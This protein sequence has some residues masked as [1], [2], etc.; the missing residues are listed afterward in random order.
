[1][2]RFSRFPELVFKMFVGRNIMRKMVF[3]LILLVVISADPPYEINPH[4]PL[5]KQ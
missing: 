1:M 3:Y 2:A 5:S 4:V